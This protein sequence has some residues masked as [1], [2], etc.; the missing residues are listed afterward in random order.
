MLF[1]GNSEF[2][3]WM[4][5]L[6]TQCIW[7]CNRDTSHYKAAEWNL[8]IGTLHKFPSNKPLEESFITMSDNNGPGKSFG[9]HEKRKNWQRRD[10]QKNKKIISHDSPKLRVP[11]LQKKKTVKWRNKIYS[12]LQASHLFSQS[13]HNDAYLLTSIAAMK[14]KDI[15]HYVR[16]VFRVHSFSRPSPARG[17]VVGLFLISKFKSM[18]HEAT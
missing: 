12:T 3:T 9:S 6:T 1:K 4:E 2:A 15:A 11:S 17:E 7:L 10:S 5:L 18:P 16:K 8:S 14:T 13:R